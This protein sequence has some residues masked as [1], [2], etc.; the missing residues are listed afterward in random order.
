M[1]Q[2]YNLRVGHTIQYL[3][4]DDLDPRKEWW[5]DHIVTWEDIRDCCLDPIEFNKNHRFQQPN[6]N[7]FSTLQ[8]HENILEID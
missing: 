7:L 4:K 1:I 2:P 8:E 6:E 3:I 5:E